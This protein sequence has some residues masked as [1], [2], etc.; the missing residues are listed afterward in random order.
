MVG[1]IVIVDSYTGEIS[2]VLIDG[3]GSCYAQQETLMKEYAVGLQASDADT[4]FLQQQNGTGASAS[5][6]PEKNCIKDVD[7]VK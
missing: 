5:G 4:R 3:I 6:K 7:M 1:L 2:G